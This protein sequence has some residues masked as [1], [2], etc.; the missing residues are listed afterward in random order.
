[1][2]VL[3]VLDGV[4]DAELESDDDDEL[5]WSCDVAAD[6]PEEEV[7]SRVACEANWRRDDG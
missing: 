4:V 1:M 3:G 6:E 2:E 7:F 5:V